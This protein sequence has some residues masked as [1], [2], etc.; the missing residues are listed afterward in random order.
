MTRRSLFGLR[1]RKQPESSGGVVLS[2]GS[3][4]DEEEVAA[5][6]ERSGDATTRSGWVA[7][8]RS[9]ACVA[10]GSFCDSCAERCAVPG[11]IVWELGKPVINDD[12]CTGCGDCV[13]LCPAPDRAIVLLP[14]D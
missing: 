5:P 10:I 1:P 6:W 14:R 11:A 8:I 9:D 13:P 2:L 4:G 7:H 12:T 3:F